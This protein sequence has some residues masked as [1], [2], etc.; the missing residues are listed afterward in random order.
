MSIGA[1]F[2]PR[3]L[4]TPM[5]RLERATSGRRSRTVTTLKR[6]RYVRARPSPRDLSDLA[7]DATFRAAAPYQR[8][9][10]EDRPDGP[11]LQLRSQ[12][13]QR[14]VRVRRA[15]N[16]VLFVV[17]ASWS[18]AVEERM[19]ATKGAIL[20]LLTDVYQRRDRVGMIVFNKDRA[21]VALPPTNSVDLAQRRLANLPVG[22]KTPLSAGL[23]L[24]GETVRQEQ[25]R[26]PELA[27]LLVI[28]TDGAGNVS[29]GGDLPPQQEAY[30]IAEQLQEA[31]IASVVINMEDVKFDQGLAQALADHLGGVC[32]NIASLQ[33]DALVEMVHSELKK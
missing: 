11:A 2:D 29:M 21:V 28:L 10:R 12:D 16:L 26:H 24:A 14:K 31:E 17:D 20:S 9:R 5:D 6:G 1:S 4:E 8:S 30:I 32:Y 13:Y 19:K 23:W 15:A 7:L 27:P 18:M 33:A 25:L 3:R 22:G